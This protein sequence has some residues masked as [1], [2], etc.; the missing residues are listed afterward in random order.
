MNYEIHLS[1][2]KPWQK[3]VYEKVAHQGGSGKKFVLKSSRQKGKSILANVLLLT[4]ATEHKSTSVVVEP[5][6]AQS[7]R[8]HKQLSDWLENSGIVK[9]SNST[10]LTIDFINGSEILFKSGEMQENLRGF[11]VSKYGILVIDEAA[12]QRQEVFEILYPITEA[13][14]APTFIISTPLFKDSEFYN[15]YMQGLNPDFPNVES[16][17]WAG[18]DMSELMPLEKVE[19]YRQTMTPLKFRSEILGEFIEEGSYLYGDI[20]KNYGYSQKEPKYVGIDWASGSNSK[21]DYSC[22]VF[23]DEDCAMVDIKFWKVIDPM[24]MVATMAGVINATPTLNTVLV[25]K[26]SLGEVYRSALQK[27]LKNK[28]VLQS[29]VTSND[30]KREIIEE[31]IKAFSENSITILDEPRLREQLQHYQIEQTPTGKV[32]YNAESGYND[33]AVMALA[34]AYKAA[35]KNKGTVRFNIK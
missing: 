34:I 10:L 2:L 15:L 35:R 26:N 11:T 3:D 16:F 29:F 12:F 33:D 17:D 30:S 13:C 20:T 7:R 19:Y 14:Q 18:Y 4:Y 24:D 23:L 1:P 32:T 9:S 25:E 8:M 6:I 21:D 5:T 27:A 31:L 22:M 28:A